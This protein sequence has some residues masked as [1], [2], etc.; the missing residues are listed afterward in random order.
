M[1]RFVYRLSVNGKSFRFVKLVTHAH[2]TLKLT[3]QILLGITDN[4]KFTKLCDTPTQSRGKT[5]AAVHSKIQNTTRSHYEENETIRTHTQRIFQYNILS[6]GVAFP[7]KKEFNYFSIIYI[8]YVFVCLALALWLRSICLFLFEI[9]IKMRNVCIKRQSIVCLF[10]YSNE[11]NGHIYISMYVEWKKCI[12]LI[13]LLLNWNSEC[14]SFCL[15][16]FFEDPKT[17]QK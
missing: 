1:I 10:A 14:F 11:Q 3:H 9:I 12:Y 4:W 8:L 13:F 7:A 15:I 6:R 2:R 16:F 17:K 5:K